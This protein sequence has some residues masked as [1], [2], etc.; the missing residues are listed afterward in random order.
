VVTPARLEL[1]EDAL[2]GA[3][4]RVGGVHGSYDTAGRYI[5]SPSGDTEVDFE[6]DLFG[7]IR[8]L[9][10]GQVALL[11]PLIET[12]RQTKSPSGRSSSTRRALAHDKSTW[13]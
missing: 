10:R 9:R 8:V 2:A 13:R 3:L 1:H 11:V 4:L 6:E 12:R 5:A 7:A